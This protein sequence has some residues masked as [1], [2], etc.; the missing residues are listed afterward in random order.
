MEEDNGYTVR[1]CVSHEKFDVILMSSATLKLRQT[2]PAHEQTYGAYKRLKKTIIIDDTIEYRRE[3][4]ISSE[5]LLGF[6]APKVLQS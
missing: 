4:C 3:F 1:V 6:W 5:Q 2:H